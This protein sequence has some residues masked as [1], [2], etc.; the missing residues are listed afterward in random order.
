MMLEMSESVTM[1]T[2]VQQ[3]LAHQKV[4][5][6]YRLYLVRLV[7]PGLRIGN[8]NLGTGMFFYTARQLH[9]AQNTLILRDIHDSQRLFELP[10]LDGEERVIGRRSQPGQAETE[11]DVDLYE[12][13]INH[14]DDPEAYRGISRR[15]ARVFFRNNTWLIQLMEGTPVPV[16]VNSVR[17]SSGAPTPLASG[18]VLSIGPTVEQYYARLTVDIT[19]R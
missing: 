12:A 13:L 2:L 3:V 16:F 10:A 5:A 8:F 6:P 17:V 7:A 11:L 9:Q 1:G 14:A 15:Q 4:Q 18:D 19:A